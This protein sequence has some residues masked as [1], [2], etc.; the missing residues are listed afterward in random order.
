MTC[1]IMSSEPAV[2]DPDVSN[3]DPWSTQLEGRVCGKEKMGQEFCCHD[4]CHPESWGTGE[5]FE[6]EKGRK[7]TNMIL[8]AKERSGF[9]IP[10]AGGQERSL[11][12]Q[13]KEREQTWV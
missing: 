12:R 11:R 5:K 3:F 9:V 2:G 7:R 10:R 8:T 4:V 13:R 1:H 6:K